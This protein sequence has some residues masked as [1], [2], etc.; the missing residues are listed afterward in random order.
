MTQVWPLLPFSF[1]FWCLE[2]PENYFQTAEPLN[3]S[4]QFS[5]EHC[6]IRPWLAVVNTSVIYKMYM[7]TVDL[8]FARRQQISEYVGEML[9]KYCRC[10]PRSCGIGG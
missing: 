3:L 10:L 7:I 1:S 4:E 2:E 9:M 8:P 6:Y 5:A